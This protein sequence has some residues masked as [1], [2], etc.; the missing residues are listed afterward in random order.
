MYVLTNTDPRSFGRKAILMFVY[1]QEPIY[2]NDSETESQVF[3]SLFPQKK[4][5]QSK[6]RIKTILI[7]EELLTMNS[8]QMG[9]K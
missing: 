1:D 2:Q 7:S 6:S 8:Y 4:F 5:H 3:N 9:T